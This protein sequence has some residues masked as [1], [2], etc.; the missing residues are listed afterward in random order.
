MDVSGPVIAVQPVL[1][2]LQAKAAE[3]AQRLGLPLLNAGQ[4]DLP[5]TLVGLL[6][7]GPEGLALRAPGK[8]APGA[9]AVDFGAGAMR[10][11]RRGGQNELLGRAVGV[12]KKPALQ[13]LDATAGLGRDAFVLADLGC[14]VTLVE[15]EPVVAALLECGLARASAAQEP[16]LREVA[17]RMRLLTG[18]ACSLAASSLGELDVIYL[19]PM[20]PQRDKSA[21]VKKEMALF[22]ALF[23][24]GDATAEP[25][26]LLAW[27]LRCPVARVVVKRPLKAAPLAGIP[28]S[29]SIR[30]KAVRY[31]VHV[32]QSLKAA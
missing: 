2:V 21:A 24:N 12:G 3:L 5:G 27:A 20:F 15:R 14:R 1:P 8:S 19:D 28:P 13:V 30:G 6:L 29:H 32:L 31:D 10:H 25:A 17:A 26:G 11:R 18:E 7:V 9:I 16:W 22:Q 23:D 4:V